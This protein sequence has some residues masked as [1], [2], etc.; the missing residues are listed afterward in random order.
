M[1]GVE[2]HE[3]EHPRSRAEGLPHDL[4]REARPTHPGE[5]DSRQAV[6][7]APPGEL[8]EVRDAFLHNVVDG[9]PAEPVGDLGRV[10]SPHRVVSRP[11]PPD[12]ALIGERSEPV[13]HGLLKGGQMAGVPHPVLPDGVDLAF[14]HRL[15]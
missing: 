10:G 2:D 11:D 8:L 6:L 5:D 3:I 15:Q 4:G 12:R 1:R 9:E 7:P 14:D 13:V